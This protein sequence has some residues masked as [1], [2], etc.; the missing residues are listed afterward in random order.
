MVINFSKQPLYNE[1]MFV[2]RGCLEKFITIKDIQ[3][4]VNAMIFAARALGY[5]VAAD[6]LEHY[7]R[8]LGGV[9]HLSRRWLR[10]FNRVSEAEG[11]NLVRFQGLIIDNAKLGVE[12]FSERR[13]RLITYN[14]VSF[15]FEE[16]FYASGDS[17]LTSRGSFTITIN[18]KKIRVK[19]LVTH[20]WHD[21]YDWH[22]GWQAEVPGFGS[23]PDA[24]LKKLQ[25][26]R[27]AREYRLAC[28]WNNRL[29]TSFNIGDSQIKWNWRISL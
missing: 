14:G 1:Q 23:I 20:N 19:G 3:K 25:T 22:V 8:G 29:D 21:K 2:Y 18:G 24:A 10:S 6:N 13:D 11:V 12:N 9:K 16:L 27:K 26:Q 7:V 15:S 5:R 4:K 28:K 17:T